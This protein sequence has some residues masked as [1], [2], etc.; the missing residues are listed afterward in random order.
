MSKLRSE[1]LVY[2]VLGLLVVYVLSVGPAF[3]LC[4]RGAFPGPVI[5]IYLPLFEATYL[6]GVGGMLSAYI[7]WWDPDWLNY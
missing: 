7:G 1:S 2:W 5:L 4:D 6:P 3:R